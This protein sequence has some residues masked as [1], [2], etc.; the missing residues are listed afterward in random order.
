[1]GNK[2]IVHLLIPKYSGN[3]LTQTSNACQKNDPFLIGTR[4]EFPQPNYQRQRNRN[5]CEVSDVI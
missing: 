4:F 1:M 2:N 5:E 3:D